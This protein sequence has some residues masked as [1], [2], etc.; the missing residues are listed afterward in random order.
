M[1]NLSFISTLSNNLLPLA[2][3]ILAFLTIVTVHEFGHF[4]FCK[5]FNV[6][7]PTFSIGLGPVLLKKHIW[8]TEFRLSLLPLGG[9][10]EIG[11]LGEPGQGTQE[12]ANDTGEQSFETK[13]YWQKMF[14]L[15]GGIAFNIIFAFTICTA[16]FMTGMPKSKIQEI[17]ITSVSSNGPADKAGIE[18]GDIIIGIDKKFFTETGETTSAAEFGNK[19]MS[20][21]DTPL[22]FFIKRDTKTHN[23]YIT[24]EAENPSDPTSPG[25]IKA[26]LSSTLLYEAMPGADLITSVKKSSTL[27]YDQIVGS[28]MTIKALFTSRSLENL[29]GPVM[30]A[31][32]LFKTAQTNIHLFLLSICY[33]SIGLA[34]TNVLPLGA[35]DGGQIFLTT[36]E[37]VTRGKLSDNFKIGLNLVSLVLFGL[38][39]IY[40]TF[41][42]TL[43]LIMK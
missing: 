27:I 12:F 11:G 8:N 3:S 36:L 14:I 16:L 15:W 17:K 41:K 2:G 26:G 25:K 28:F 21:K 40:L 38:L 33:V 13:P 43:A 18:V 30:I 29:G 10:V 20:S 1:I 24:P 32:Q 6:R 5:I 39:F 4:I 7:T 34:I 22:H 23:I 9:F 37:A 31:S 35:L 42:D 19:I